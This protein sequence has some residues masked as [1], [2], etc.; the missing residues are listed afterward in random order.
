M[1]ISDCNRGIDI[2][3]SIILTNAPPH[4]VSHT[5]T[6]FFVSLHSYALKHGDSSAAMI[7]KWFNVR[8]LTT[9]K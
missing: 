9:P 6:L 7:F 1:H 3:I 4:F 5:K 8:E 2:I